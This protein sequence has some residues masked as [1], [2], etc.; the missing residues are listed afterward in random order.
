METKNKRGGKRLNAG[1]KPSGIK[2]QPITTYISKEIIEQHG[3]PKLKIL[4][5]DFLNNY[6]N[7]ITPL[8]NN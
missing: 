5:I 8:H 2:K 6:K 4:I 7:V 1:R 3:K